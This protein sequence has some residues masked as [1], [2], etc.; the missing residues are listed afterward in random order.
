MAERDYSGMILI[1]ASACRILCMERLRKKKRCSRPSTVVPLSGD[2]SRMNLMEAS[3]RRVLSMERP[4]KKMVER[5]KFLPCLPLD[6]LG[7]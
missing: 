3:A 4:R 2:Y 5:R 6:L 7:R 1:E